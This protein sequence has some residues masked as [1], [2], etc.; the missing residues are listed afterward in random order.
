MDDIL[1]INDKEI[2]LNE[3]KEFLKVFHLS[4]NE[5][6]TCVDKHFTFFNMKFNNDIT[7]KSMN[8]NK[9]K[10]KY[11]QN[12]VNK[13]DIND[14]YVGWRNYAKHTDTNLKENDKKFKKFI[15]CIDI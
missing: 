1:I 2:D 13:S 3:I 9:Y 14:A 12:L 15:N 7:I 11:K 6:K 8:M 5:E 10:T 4:L